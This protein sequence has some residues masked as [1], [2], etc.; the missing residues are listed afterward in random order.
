M[1]FSKC[2]DCEALITWEGACYF[3]QEAREQAVA[4]YLGEV[5]NQAHHERLAALRADL[6]DLRAGLLARG[7][8]AVIAATG[9]SEEA[10]N[11][12]LRGVLR[13]PLKSTLARLEPQ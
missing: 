9:L 11:A 8:P 13:P 3:C 12:Q 5:R 6:D 7:L 1:N 4:E 10:I 2:N